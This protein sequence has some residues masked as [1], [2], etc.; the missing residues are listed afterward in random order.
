VWIV[1]VALSR[2]YTFVVLA[3]AILLLGPLAILRMPVD[4]FPNIGIPVVAIVWNY[5]GL[6]A[7]E[8]S[9]RLVTIHERALTT[10]VNGIEHIESQSLRGTGVVKV[11]FQPGASIE[12]AV[13][14][15]TAVSQ[16]ILRQMPTGT[17][18]P[19]V[20]SYNASTVPVLQLALSGQSLSEQQLF[21]LGTNFLRTRLATVQGASIPL[22]YGGRQPQVQVDLDPAALRAKGLSPLDVVNALSVQ[23]LILPAGTSKIGGVEY[24]VRINGSPQ[25]VAEMNDLP[26]RTVGRTPI[27]VRDVAHVR[28]GSPPQTNV[29]RVNGQ[30]ATLMAILKNGEASTLDVIERVKTALPRILASLPPELKVDALADQ[31]LFVRASI[32][33]VVREAVIAAVLTALLILVLL[34]SWRSTLIVATSIPLSILASLIMLGAMRETINIMTL[35]GLA[36]AIGILVDNGIVAI[37]NISAH[38]E[39]G[40]DLEPAILD[41]AEQITVPT[42]V[43]TVCICIVFVPMFFLTGVGRYLFVPMAEAVVFAMLASFA[44]SRTLVPTMAKY[45]L[46]AH[47]PDRHAER[48]RSR[49]PLVRFQGRADDAFTRLREAYGAVLA[50]CLERRRAVAVVFLAGCAASLGLVPWLGRDFF[51]AVDSG[52][53]KL[54]LRAPTGTRI[55]ETA[56]LTDR[57]EQAIRGVIPAREVASII[58]NIGLPYSGINLTYSNSAPIGPYD[59]DILVSLAAEHRPTAGHVRALRRELARRFPGVL[60]SFI[61]ADIVSQILSFGLPAPVDVQVVGR[62]AEANQQFA[63]RL[64][65]Q[66]ARVPGV[67]DLRVHQA[68]NQPQLRWEVDRTRAAQAGYTQREVASNL[69]IS[70]SGSAQTTPTFWLNPATG[71]SYAVATQTPQYRIGS[72]HDLGGIPVTGASGARPQLLEN[73]ATVSRGAAAA[74]VSHYDVQPVVDIFGAVQGRDLGGVASE[75]RRIVAASEKQLPRGSQVFVRGQIETMDASFRGL[76]GGLVLAVVLVYLLIVVNFQS[77]LDPFIIISALPAALAGIVWMLFLTGTTTSVPALTGAIMCVGVATANSILVVSFAKD[78]IAKGRSPVEAAR[79]AGVARFRP[80]LMTALAMVI[81]MV[82]MALGLGEGGEQNAPLGRAV[83]GGLVLATVATLFFVPAVFGVLHGRHGAH[84]PGE[85]VVGVMEET[86]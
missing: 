3:I 77:W 56:G 68:F 10:T 9:T 42:F 19:L 46:E 49:N 32:E 69:L 50:A 7:D 70:L 26:I 20:I 33:G 81:G 24:D 31:S 13:A 84:R 74:V 16:A 36:L 57:V 71:V 79:G 18:P 65:A 67:V 21:D 62:D 27:Y 83:I 22:P 64:A 43:A 60:F 17:T 6:S 58:D 38:L 51:P 59:A 53:F 80:V 23:N 63:S 15:V 35:G 86:G 44:L 8:I 45:L 25:T 76:L 48:R 5:A 75:I 78:E 4:I 66:L 39:Q 73:L 82:P 1:R 72:L 14:Q 12:M 54:H 28:N 11:F 85:P 40:K 41:G 52:Q 34:G 30:R 55:E 2:P 61:P 29:V 47:A 37:E